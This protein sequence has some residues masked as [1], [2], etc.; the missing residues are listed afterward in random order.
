MTESF[1]FERDLTLLPTS[2]SLGRFMGSPHHLH[3]R[4][5]VKVDSSGC[6]YVTLSLLQAGQLTKTDSAVVNANLLCRYLV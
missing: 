1:A 3:G 6:G 4:L 2:P 5:D